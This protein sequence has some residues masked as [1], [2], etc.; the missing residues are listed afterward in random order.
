MLDPINR[1]AAGKS[2]PSL[3]REALKH[4]QKVFQMLNLLRTYLFYIVSQIMSKQNKVGLTIPI[5]PLK[6]NFN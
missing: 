4:T 3:A 6:I 1:L 5:G 2:N